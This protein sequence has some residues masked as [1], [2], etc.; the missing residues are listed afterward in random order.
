MKLIRI[1]VD[2]S[3]IR[4]NWMMVRAFDGTKK[5]ICREVDLK[6]LAGPSEFEVSFVIV[7][8]PTVFNLLLGRLWIHSAGLI[9]IK[10]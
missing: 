8:T 4:P 7:D 10:R 2:D 9:G 1:S 5:S 3:M 6:I